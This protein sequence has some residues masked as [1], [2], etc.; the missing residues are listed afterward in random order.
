MLGFS[1]KSHRLSLMSHRSALLRLLAFGRRRRS[2]VSR[3]GTIGS[4]NRFD[5]TSL[6]LHTETQAELLEFIFDL[7]ERLLAEVTILEHFAL[8][9]LRELAN[10]GDV[11]VVQAVSRAHAKLDF[12]DAHVEQ[13]LQLQVLFAHTRR[14]LVELDDLFVEVDE[15]IEVVA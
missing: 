1:A 7:V 15:N 9:L 12:V 6:E 4:R 5:Q 13:L 3:S 10:G 8:G 14:R 2:A 11:G